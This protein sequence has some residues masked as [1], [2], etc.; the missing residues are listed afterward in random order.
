MSKPVA[1]ARSASIALA[2]ERIG[3]PMAL[4]PTV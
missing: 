2:L 1:D 3:S 4:L